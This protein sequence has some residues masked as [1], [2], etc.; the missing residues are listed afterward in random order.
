M[1]PL[2]RA[3]AQISSNMLSCMKILYDSG[4]SVDAKDAVSYCNDV[5]CV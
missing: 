2:H 4:A 1:T 5:I 3:A